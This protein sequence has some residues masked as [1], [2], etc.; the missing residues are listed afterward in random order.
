MIS[1]YTL[2]E[3]SHYISSDHSDVWEKSSIYGQMG[4]LFIVT[5]CCMVCILTGLVS[6]ERLVIRDFVASYPMSHQII[7]ND[8]QST[9]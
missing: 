6:Q 3:H 2:I 5:T 1:E 8:D 9:V 4:S 7:D